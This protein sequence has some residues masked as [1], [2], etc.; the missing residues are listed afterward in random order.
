MTSIITIRYLEWRKASPS[1]LAPTRI[2]ETFRPNKYKIMKT[3]K[4]NKECNIEK[5]NLKEVGNIEIRSRYNNIIQIHTII[6][7]RS[8]FF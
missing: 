3:L 7:Q 1:S 4:F 8:S 6:I 2:G 5:K